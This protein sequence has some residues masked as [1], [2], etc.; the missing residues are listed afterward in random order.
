MQAA[1]ALVGS[2][3][4]WLAR[5]TRLRA[6]GLRAGL[7]LIYHKLGDPPGAAE[8]DLVPALDPRLFEAQLRHLASR[9]RVVPAGKIQAAASDPG[10]VDR[11]GAGATQSGGF[12]RKLLEDR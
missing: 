11:G 10:E 2:R 7:V 4:G 1:K 9:Y 12:L 8:R 3:A 5:Y 6:S